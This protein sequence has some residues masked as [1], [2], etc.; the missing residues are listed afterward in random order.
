M[1]RIALNQ[2]KILAIV[3]HALYLILTSG[4]FAPYANMASMLID[5]EK[6]ARFVEW[7]TV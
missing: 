7:N 4:Q 5:L 1:N 2:Q 6:A 3:F